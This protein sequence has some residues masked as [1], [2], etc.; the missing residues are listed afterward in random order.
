MLSLFHFLQSEANVDETVYFSLRLLRL[1]HA[2][3][4]AL[5]L[6]EETNH[7]KL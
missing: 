4:S 1:V 3:G 6:R 5:D 7:N 2:F